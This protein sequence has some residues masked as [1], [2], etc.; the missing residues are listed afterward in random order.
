[1]SRKNVAETTRD[2]VTWGETAGSVLVE[3]IA[4]IREVPFTKEC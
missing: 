1:M 4:H 3:E 2:G